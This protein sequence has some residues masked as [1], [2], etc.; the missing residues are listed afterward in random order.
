MD[1]F[2]KINTNDEDNVKISKTA[3]YNALAPFFDVDPIPDND[4]TQEPNI[5]TPDYS[6]MESLNEMVEEEKRAKE[7]PVLVSADTKSKGTMLY[8]HLFKQIN[9]LVEGTN[10]NGNIDTVTNHPIDFAL[11]QCITPDVCKNISYKWLTQ[12]LHD[13]VI[14]F[15][16]AYDQLVKELYMHNLGLTDENTLDAFEPY[17]LS[18][19]QQGCP[20][21]MTIESSWDFN[22]R[23]RQEKQEQRKRWAKEERERK[24]Q[25]RQE[26]FEREEGPIP[27][28]RQ[29]EVFKLAL[30][31]QFAGKEGTPPTA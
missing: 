6:W 17:K 29:T 2:N 10:E 9:Q 5:K 16:N 24:K 30:Q 11:K 18:E 13:N 1:E 19:I 8:H 12:K 22:Q 31:K 15:D 21:G 4:K 7:H 14:G 23:K 3:L 27:T 25:E 26:R 28:R 20:D